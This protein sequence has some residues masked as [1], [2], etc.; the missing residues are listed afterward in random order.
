MN[1]HDDYLYLRI[2][3]NEFPISY[4]SFCVCGEEQAEE[5]E[6]GARAKRGG[7]DMSKNKKNEI[8]NNI[9]SGAIS[10]PIYWD[11]QPTSRNEQT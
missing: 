2:M 6:E 10:K 4:F 5:K 7:G 3:K 8:T 11:L 9:F 1:Q